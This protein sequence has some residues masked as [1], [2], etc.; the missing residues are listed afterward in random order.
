M[1]WG[2]LP[3]AAVP[4][5][6]YTPNNQ[7]LVYIKRGRGGNAT[8]TRSRRKEQEEESLWPIYSRTS[9]RKGAGRPGGL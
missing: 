6:I 9:S 1:L 4:M 8:G 5:Y 2:R 7:R 3:F